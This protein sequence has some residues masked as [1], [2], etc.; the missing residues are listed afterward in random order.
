MSGGEGRGWRGWRGWLGG[1]FFLL[2]LL[3]G[4]VGERGKGRGG[5]GG[6]DVYLSCDPWVTFELEGRFT[7]IIGDLSLAGDSKDEYIR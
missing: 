5:G 2:L 6:V 3:V 4:L 7:P 1:S